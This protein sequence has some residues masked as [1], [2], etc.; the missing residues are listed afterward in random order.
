MFFHYNARPSRLLHLFKAFSTQALRLRHYRTRHGWITVLAIPVYLFALMGYWHGPAPAS[1]GDLF[2]WLA[3]AG[4]G[5][6]ILGWGYS[7]V[8]RRY[9]YSQM[10]VGNRIGLGIAL[11]ILSIFLLIFLADSGTGMTTGPLDLVLQPERS[12]EVVSA[13]LWAAA[14]LWLLGRLIVWRRLGKVQVEEFELDYLNR[15]L[16]P[17]LRDLPAES[18]CWLRC[19]PFAPIW[20]AQRREEPGRPGRFFKVCDDILLDLKTELPDGTEFRLSTLH[21]RLDK[22]KR[23]SKKVKYKGTKHRIAQVYRFRHPAIQAM[24]EARSADCQN[25]AQLWKAKAG[26]FVS[27]LRRSKP[28][29]KLTVVQKHKTGGMNRE[30]RGEDLPGADLT[31][32]TVKQVSAWIHETVPSQRPA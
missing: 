10:T 12:H 30:L 3:A 2:P 26:G 20:T 28:E 18:R 16:K 1:F 4:S 21:R 15:V 14:W 27:E 22:H 7:A 23:T 19:N 13:W 11:L 8:L 32:E 31:L 6:M 5:F 24:G 25:L 9:P 17:L 29:G